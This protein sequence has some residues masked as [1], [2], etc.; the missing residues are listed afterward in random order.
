MSE[1]SKTCQ[2]GT[3]RLDQL[4][5]ALL[6]QIASIASKFF[7][8]KR[9]FFTGTLQLNKLSVFSCNEIEIDRDGFVF[10]V[11]EVDD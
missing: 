10:L 3:L 1:P 5:H 7:L 11:V 2:H 4:C 6:S 9:R 8:R